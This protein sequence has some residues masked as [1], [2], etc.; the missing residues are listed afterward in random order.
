[1]LWTNHFSYIYIYENRS[2]RTAP[3]DERSIKVRYSKGFGQ[4]SLCG[5]VLNMAQN[6]IEPHCEH[7]L[8]III[9]LSIVYIYIYI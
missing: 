5:V 1:M 4:I 8:V 2:N 6:Y 7:L 9:N 3:H